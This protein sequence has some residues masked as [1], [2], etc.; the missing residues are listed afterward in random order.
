VSGARFLNWWIF[1]ETLISALRACIQY[2]LLQFKK[3]AVY[4]S[5]QHIARRIW[6]SGASLMVE[7]NK[8]PGVSPDVSAIEQQ[9]GGYEQGH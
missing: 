1:L 8:Q 7:A 4:A 5:G 6:I 2:Y 3:Q 9:A